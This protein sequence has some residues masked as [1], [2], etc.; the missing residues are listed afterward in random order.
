MKTVIINQNSQNG[1][2]PSAKKHSDS[3]VSWN[4]G[5]LEQWNAG[6][7]T[8]AP[9]SKRDSSH[10]TEPPVCISR[11]CRFGRKS[12]LPIFQ[13]SSIPL[14]HGTIVTEKIFFTL[15]ELL[16]VIAI[17]AILASMLL[18]ALGKA[19]QTA[20]RS[21]CLSNHKQ[22]GLALL[23]YADDN[24]GVYPYYANSSPSTGLRASGSYGAQILP[25]YISFEAANCP[26]VPLQIP[27]RYWR[28]IYIIAGIQPGIMNYDLVTVSRQGHYKV[29]NYSSST[30]KTGPVCGPTSP[31][32][33]LA[34]DWFFGVGIYTGQSFGFKNYGFTAAHEGK[35]SNS[36]F[37]DGHAEWFT[38]PRGRA[39]Y[40]Y[41]EFLSIHSGQY[42][43]NGPYTNSHWNQ[44]PY[45]AFRPR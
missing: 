4:D 13:H 26:S 12:L 41:N 38:N 22:V 1:S 18:P 7:S 44:A 24:D 11:R 34:T 19:R 32:R 6:L 2:Q 36:V 15:I 21:A 42:Y 17:I 10:L 29:A 16:V 3:T 37:E 40:T 5:I 14:F 39:P 27:D 45:V 43:A 30:G 28:S 9:I 31:E 20:T 8:N 23:N 25:A 35:G 33:V